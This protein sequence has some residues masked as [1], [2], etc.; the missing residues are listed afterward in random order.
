MRSVQGTLAWLGVVLR[1]AAVPRLTITG[2]R[3]SILGTWQDG[4]M[5]TF[6][7]VADADI[8]LELFGLGDLPDRTAPGVTYTIAARGCAKDSSSCS[9]RT[10][11]HA[12]IARGTRISSAPSSAG[13]RAIH[14]SWPSE[15]RP[16]IY[17]NGA[18]AGSARPAGVPL[19]DVE[20]EMVAHVLV[21]SVAPRRELPRRVT[22]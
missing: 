10:R 6:P 17:G 13:C 4:R 12:T 15:L 20:I 2:E 3:P 21:R 18:R 16:T 1:V 22:A 11:R 5:H 7:G 9:N 19:D 8:N 14:A